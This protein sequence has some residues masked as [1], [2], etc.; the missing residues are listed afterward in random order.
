NVKEGDKMYKP[1]NE[2]IVVW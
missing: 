2:R 1:E